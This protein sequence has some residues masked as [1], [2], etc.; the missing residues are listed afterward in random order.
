ME[1]FTFMSITT[2]YTPGEIPTT[3]PP[4]LT[5]DLPGSPAYRPETTPREPKTPRTPKAPDAPSTAPDRPKTP[6]TIHPDIDPDLPEKPG[7][8]LS[9]PE[10]PHGTR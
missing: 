7:P 5:P 3:T 10:S 9:D 8:P 2:P 1:S 4:E 6:P